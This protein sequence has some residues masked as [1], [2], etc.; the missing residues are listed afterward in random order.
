MGQR[1]FLIVISLVFFGASVTIDGN[2]TL[3]GRS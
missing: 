1:H 3:K 2:N